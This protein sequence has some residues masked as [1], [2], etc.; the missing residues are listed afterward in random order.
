MNNLK[1]VIYEQPDMRTYAAFGKIPYA[2]LKKNSNHK[3]KAIKK[4]S[5]I[6][7]KKYFLLL[8]LLLTKHKIKRLLRSWV[9]TD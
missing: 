9:T 3:P 7:Q 8:G 1:V 2:L 6:F 4:I 5:H